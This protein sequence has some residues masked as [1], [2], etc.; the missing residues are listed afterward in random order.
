MIEI[1]MM[2]AFVLALGLSLW[3]VYMFVPNKP[4]EDDD[5][6]EASTEELTKLLHICLHEIEDECLE[7]ERVFEQIVQH[8]R[9]DK[10]HFWR[11]NENRL[12]QLLEVEYIKHHLTDTS[13]ALSTPH[14]R[15]HQLKS[16]SLH[17]QR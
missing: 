2:V 5:K 6:N 14:Q 15:I 10:K 7:I 16:L 3:K 4:L 12:R 8:E 1:A 9:F 17:H 11:F 13:D